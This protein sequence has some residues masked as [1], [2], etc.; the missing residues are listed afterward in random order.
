[1]ANESELTT[2]R[3]LTLLVHAEKTVAVVE[4][5]GHGILVAILHVADDGN[6]GKLAIL[7]V[8]NVNIGDATLDGQGVEAGV[9]LVWSH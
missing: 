3:K 7:T 8:N 4:H 9:S 5:N 1:M 2:N 6:G